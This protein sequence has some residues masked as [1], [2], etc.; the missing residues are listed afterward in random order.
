MSTWIPALQGRL[1]NTVALARGGNSRGP[2]C[3][4]QSRDLSHPNHHFSYIIQLCVSQVTF[5][6]RGSPYSSVPQLT[7]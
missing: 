5:T 2:A 7:P 4:G 3:Q 6:T 1:S